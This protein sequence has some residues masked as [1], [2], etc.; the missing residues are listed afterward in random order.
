MDVLPRD[1][2][3]MQVPHGRRAHQGAR[4]AWR[5]SWAWLRMLSFRRQ[6]HKKIARVLSEPDATERRITELYAKAVAQL[7][8]DE[9]PVRFGGLYALERLAQD[10]PAHRQSIVN[11]IC[12][13]LRMPFSPTA[14]ASKPESEVGE[15]QKEP[16]TEG[17][18]EADGIDRTWQQERQV[19][20]TAQRILA[21]HLRDDRTKDP[22]S[23]DTPSSRFWNNIRLDLTGATLVDF[24]LV[25]GVM[26]D[27]SFHGATFSGD[28]WFGEATFTGDA[29]FG[30]ATFS[31]DASFGRATFSG[32]ARFGRATFSAAA[33][34]GGATFSGA[35]QFGR[36][37]FSGDALFGRATF[38]GNAQF[39]RAT[40]SGDALFGEAAFSRGAGFRRV[41]F[42]GAAGFHNAAFDG[43][44]GFRKA[45][46]RGD[47]WFDEATFGG[48]AW[49]DK[50]T[51]GGD[52]GF[53]EAAFTGVAGFGEAAFGGDAWFDGAAFG[54]DAW[55][56]EA[57]FGSDAW[58]GEATFG[59]DTGFDM[60]AFGGR[61]WF[62]EAAFGGH[63]WFGEATFSG[64]ADTLNFEHARVLSPGAS[65]SWP[66]GWCLADPD[67][68][69]Y[70]VVRASDDGDF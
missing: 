20:L 31:A 66:T 56:G 63:A 5:R 25:N 27:A 44:G 53:G 36:A 51:I 41:V 65:H 38:R 45:A 55:F 70:T 58:F 57:A 22:Q 46:F 28:A 26:A 17:E 8:G 23:T 68:G 11:V 50:A 60:A 19:R 35:A 54:G 24:N 33:Q 1:D 18:A 62:G 6:H 47:A 64:G 34:F 7:A 29:R 15:G 30:R 13:Y 14:P 9:A 43:G 49:F 10:S 42:G 37:T 52:A 40:F 69:G 39:G 2:V 67:G 61:A 12:A 4:P 48:D 59:G 32:D 3:P 16:G 21:E